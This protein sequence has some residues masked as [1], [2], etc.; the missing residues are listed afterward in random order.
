MSLNNF[1]FD[2]LFECIKYVN[3]KNTLVNLLYVSKSV[4]LIANQIIK[5]NLKIRI[6]WMNY[7]LFICEHMS[8][9]NL[10]FNEWKFLNKSILIEIDTENRK[11]SRYYSRGMVY[12]N[13]KIIIELFVYD[14]PLVFISSRVFGIKKLPSFLSNEIFHS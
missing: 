4:N 6:S 10:N 12:C 8:Q 9:W 11:D 2:L 13:D 7:S 14:I 3:D 1:N 5:N